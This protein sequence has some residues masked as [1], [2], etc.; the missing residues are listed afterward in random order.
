[1]FHIQLVHH[2]DLYSVAHHRLCL[3]PTTSRQLHVERVDL[4]VLW[5]NM[6]WGHTEWLQDYYS[7]NCQWRDSMHCK[8]YNYSILQHEFLPRYIKSEIFS[9]SININTIIIAPVNCEWSSW[10]WGTCTR[11]CGGG[12]K[13]GSRTISQQAANGG[14]A[15]TGGSTTTRSCNTNSCP[16]ILNQKEF[17]SQSTETQLL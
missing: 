4:A 2:L 6:W 11:T 13:S 9:N 7:T 15:C 3:C 17:L 1:M 10:S 5:Q 16:G 14:T 12:T 8:S